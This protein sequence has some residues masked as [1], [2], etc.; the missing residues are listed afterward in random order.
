MKKIVRKTLLI[1]SIM[2]SLSSIKTYGG[3]FDVPIEEFNL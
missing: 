1:I 2:I 3:N